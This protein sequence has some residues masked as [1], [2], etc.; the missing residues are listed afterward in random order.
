MASVVVTLVLLG[1]RTMV[2]TSVL[3]MVVAG[4]FFVSSVMEAV[5]S[6]KA[7]DSSLV[8]LAQPDSK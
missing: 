2:W 7:V 5:V 3:A 6:M 8:G 4:A 1:W